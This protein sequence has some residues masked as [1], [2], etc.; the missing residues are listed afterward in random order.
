MSTDLLEDVET[1]TTT[2]DGDH[3][4]FARYFDEDL[5]RALLEGV[6][7]GGL[8]GKATRPRSRTGRCEN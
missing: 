8:C 7:I 4:K 6:D 5:D 2:S 1:I 3:D